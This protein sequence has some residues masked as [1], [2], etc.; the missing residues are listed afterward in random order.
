MLNIVRVLFYVVA[1]VTVVLEVVFSHL[2]KKY[3]D[4]R[5]DD[6]LPLFT[7]FIIWKLV[8]LNFQMMKLMTHYSMSV[9]S[10]IQDLERD[11]E[12]YFKRGGDKKK[13]D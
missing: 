13:K 7:L 3:N 2:T 11:S 4:T 10:L 9:M 12:S 6:F 5:W 8:G 1:V